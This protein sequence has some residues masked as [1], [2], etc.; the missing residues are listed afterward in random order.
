MH[1]H[2]R[3]ISARGNRMTS[4][5]T[6]DTDAPEAAPAA[7]TPPAEAAPAA[8]RRSKRWWLGFAASFLVVVLGAELGIR[9][10]EDR[11]SQPLH[12][13]SGN[14]ETVVHDMEVL[15][16]AGIKSDIA[17]VG[18]SQVRRSVEDDQVERELGVKYAHNVALPGAQTPVVKR[19]ML[20]EVVPRIHPKRVVWG[21]QSIDFNANRARKS[22]VFYNRA[23]ETKQGFYGAADRLLQNSAISDHR[24]EL[25]DPVRLSQDL[26]G[27]PARFDKPR[28]LGD[29]ASWAT[30]YGK[31]SEAQLRRIRANHRREV[32]DQQL[33]DFEIGE[34]E[35][36]AYEDT[37]TGLR[38]Q[39]IEV[40]VVIMPVPSHYFDLHPGGKADWERWRVAVTAAAERIGVPIFDMSQ[41]IPDEGFRDSEH[42]L[43]KP[44]R[45]F[46]KQL[47]TKLKDELGW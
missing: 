33:L 36:R 45:D 22:I 4:G 10:G 7:D 2:T 38:D 34:E 29:R 28:P 19:W 9:L 40:A 8:F 44:A 24:V 47:D 12:Y 23:R 5:V 26:T 32:R 39:G 17:F 1:T 25:R 6:D 37:L 15:Q 46:T 27:T 43:T 21:T 18:T 30:G 16:A 13:F 11:I 3:G 20:E 35:M 31:I 41:S 42:M 14:A